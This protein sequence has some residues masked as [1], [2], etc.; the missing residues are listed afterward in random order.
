LLL[1]ALALWLCALQGP[2]AC[3]P[4]PVVAPESGAA[5]YRAWG[6][7]EVPGGAVDAV[8]GNLMLEGVEISLDTPL[9]TQ[10]IQPTWNSAA[11]AWQWSQLARYDGA[12]FVDPGG[13]RLDAGAV[14]DGAPIPGSG[15]TRLSASALRTRGGLAWHFAPDGSLAHLRWATLDYPRIVFT[16]ALISQCL[17]PASCSALFELELHPSGQ[18]TRVRDARS[19]R[20]A[21]FDYDAEGR[22]LAARSP[23]DVAEGRPGRRYEYV[24]SQLRAA[25]SSEGERVEYG[26]QPGGR[27]RRVLQRGEGD[28]AH[29]FDFYGR[30]P[31]GQHLTVHRNPLGGH[32]HVYFDE[33]RR[34][35]RIERFEAGESAWLEWQ[36]LRPT[37]IVDAGGAA[38]R[39]EW[40]SER[41]ASLETPS[42]NRV[43]LTYQPDGLS[44]EDPLKDPI[45]RVEDSLGL[46]E[47]RSYDAS[48]RPV[49]VENG[50]GESRMLDWDG[51]RLA[52]VDSGGVAVD[53]PRFGAHGHWLDALTGGEVTARRAF[54]IVGNLTLPAD[55][56]RPGGALGFGY[57][58]DRRLVRADFAASDADGRVV[59]TSQIAI[60]RRGDGALDA[61][62][63]PAGGD[64]ELDHDSLG[65]PV[66]IRER[67]Q[68]VWRETRIEYDAMGNETA[69]ER[70]NGMR[71][72]WERDL[73]GRVVRHRA[74]RGGALEGEQS[75]S[76]HASRLAARS[77]SLRGGGEVYVYDTAGRMI[78]VVFGY[79]ETI[80]FTYDARDRRVREV[81]SL[82]GAGVI[83]DIGTSYDLADRRVA[84]QDL[85]AGQTLVAWT[86]ADGRLV[87]V[88]TGNGLDR[89]LDYDAQGRAV[90]FETRD[91]QNALV[92][93][94]AIART[95]ASNPPRL[96]LS[97]AT[98]TVL[99]ATEE[100][101]WLP[102]GSSLLNLD[103]RAGKRVFG[104]SD[105]ADGSRRYAWDE[106]GNRT[107]ALGDAFAYDT[108][109]ARL[110]SATLAHEGVSL[111]YTYD[112]AGFALSRGGVPL[113]WSAMG[114]LLRHGDD[115]IEW[116]MVG[117]PIRV[118]ESGVEREFQLFG[119][120]IESTLSS[121]GA[122]DLGDV[123]IQLGNGARR[124]R[125]LD[126]R[127]Q[128]SFV[129]DEQGEVVAHYRYHPFGVD[130]AFG[131]EASS[132]RFENRP[133]FGPFFLLGERVLDPLVGR[134][135]SPDPVMQ[136]GSAYA[137]AYGNPI[138]F[139]DV[140]GRDP[141]PRP[142]S[143]IAGALRVAASAV[144]M[145]SLIASGA[146]S[147]AVAV[148]LLL[149]LAV[150][151]DFRETYGPPTPEGGPD[152]SQSGGGGG[153][154]SPGGSGT[155]G[156]G[157]G[158]SGGCG[159]T[160][161][162][163][164]GVA[165]P[166]STAT[167]VGCAPL[168]L[169]RSE[170]ELGRLLLP[171]IVINALVAFAWW[172]RRDKE[173][174]RCSRP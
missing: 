76:W 138:E 50:E 119:G 84:L 65:R 11:G 110:L 3:V 49:A 140:D 1:R 5:E 93:S 108:Q 36:G 54:D 145:A 82:P 121:L 51:A 161:D 30:N 15:W 43:T 91:A 8:G 150:V 139:A 39:I 128:V 77:D 26:Y 23:A 136:L 44:P 27:I 141:A 81:Y 96:E 148:A 83:A 154:G 168:A 126:F 169:A 69:R 137:Y 12:T 42:G 156:G 35:L 66:R 24:G 86:Y 45:A 159:C 112:E 60:S 16:P 28:P 80:S 99:A 32:T 160:K 72:E 10:R 157:G 149:F 162:L 73:F 105:G 78:S 46:V 111:A 71:Q 75:F 31:W 135:L 122:L 47:S 134:F 53:F 109:R 158:G 17:A 20:E 170:D 85:D 48:G 25:T 68:G 100:R 34:V 97:S 153:G 147:A 104:W 18:P 55:T 155:G 172:R 6:F 92:E 165:G 22:L 33:Q 19:G 62:A 2:L 79:G 113:E 95:L 21:L 133:A 125:H 87:G 163:N 64:T 56:S 52:G 37:R 57:D 173:K 61:I 166:S 102:P 171:L 13:A 114:R 74:L 152:G 106:L 118:T 29:V 116:D 70:A 4:A 143:M 58:A 142:G 41:V 124:W 174:V 130:A 167:G 129:S 132:G 131:P 115:R 9:G 89:S 67:S 146:S 38:T 164:I 59:A 94:T 98:T 63:R 103:Q 144:L 107:G 120:R 101:Y 90:G 7:I 117:R 40:V 151:I 88:G 123:V 14:P 127:G